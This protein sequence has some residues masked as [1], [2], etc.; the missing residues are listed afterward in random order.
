V[1]GQN[2]YRLH[3]KRF[4]QIG[5]SWLKHSFCAVDEFDEMFCGVCQPN[6]DCDWLAIGCADT[7]GT[8]LNGNQP[9]MGPRSEVNAANGAY[10]FPYV[11]Q[12]GASGDAIFKRLQVQVDDLNPDLNPGAQYFMEAYYL[13]TDEQAWANQYNNASY[14]ECFV[15]GLSGGGYN[16]SY[17][18]GIEIEQV[19]TGLDAWQDIDTGVQIATISI[20]GDGDLHVG[21]RATDNQ[22]GTWHY[23]YAVYNYNSDRSV[24]CFSVPTG[25]T[26]VTNA[27]F[28]DVDSHSGEPYSIAD[29]TQI[30]LGGRYEWQSETFDV[31]ADANAIRWNTMYSFRFD[32]PN[33]PVDG[34]AKIMLFKPGADPE[35]SVSVVHPMREP[36]SA[37]IVEANGIVNVN[38]LLFLL[39]EWGESGLSA[40]DIDGTS[41]Q[42]PDDVVDV[43]DLLTLLAQ[44]GSCP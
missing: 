32:S 37:D 33:P 5:M 13:T 1:I 19:S 42:C 27:G 11:L 21:S 17:N 31:N 38:D 7:Y 14:R 4:D 16:L 2:L 22:D 23:E 39:A 41:E 15:G 9:G 3:D 8:F 34:L 28:N 30:D 44:W 18:V 24:Q 20:A 43:T 10:T 36:C 25:C 12:A 29:W 26:T 40:A 6:F 35:Q